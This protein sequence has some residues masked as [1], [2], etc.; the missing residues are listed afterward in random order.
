MEKPS[1][2]GQ[3]Q[4]PATLEQHHPQFILQLLDLPAQ[5]RL[6]DVQPFSGAGE[7]EGLS[8]HLKVT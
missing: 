4:R 5:G 8:Q 3:P 6:G 2:V 1:G 7:I